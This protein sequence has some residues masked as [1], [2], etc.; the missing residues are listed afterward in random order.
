MN[1][2][3]NVREIAVYI[4]EAIANKMGDEDMFDANWYELEDIV[5]R[6]ILDLKD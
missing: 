6:K 4:L 3:S 5:I 1:D 2:K